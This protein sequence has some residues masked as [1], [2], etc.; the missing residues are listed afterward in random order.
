MNILDKV[1]AYFNPERAA[2]RA[3]FRSSLERGYDAASTD[4]LSGDWMPVF[5]TAEQVAS[6]QRDLIR[7]RARAAELNSDLAESVVLA[8]LRNVVGT[9]IKPQCKIKT[10]AGKLNERLNK[11]IEE[12]WSDWVDKENADIRGISTF[13]ELQEMALRRMVYD[14]EILV[15]MTFE[16]TDIPLSLQLIEG[17]NIGAVSVSENG[18]SIVNGV[19][20]NKYGRPI[21]YHVFQTDPLGIRLFNEARLPSNR[22]FLLHK[23]RRP[24][25]LRGVSML[26]LVL[27][28][29]HDVDEYMDADLIAARVA[30]CFGAFV[31]SNTGGNPMVANKIDSKGKKV[32][33]MAPGIIQH[34]RA[35]ESIS[36]AEPKRNAGTASEYSATQTR[37]IAS[38]MGLS[39]DIVTRNI[40]GNFSAARQNMLE[41]QQSFKQMQRFIIEHFCMPVWQA[42]IEACYLKGIIPANDY[43]ANPK[44]YKKV[45]WLAP[46]WSWIDP[47][48]EVNAN[49]EAIKAG[50][51]T[52]EDVCSASGKDWEEVLEQRKL[53]Q[54]RIKELGVALDM[55]G[56]ITNLADDNA[57]DMKGDDS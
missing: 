53:E 31:T 15:N 27:K 56:D 9:G 22:A 16:G 52:L 39:A 18:N 33:S 20:V 45:A 17:E 14:G 7:G 10:K 29:I 3:Y 36:F 26:A 28:R 19:E 42:F 8:L 55:N 50:L 40:S 21:A 12:A 11:K 1:I 38:G 46:G 25:E 5:G 49:K 47:V 44:L 35:G 2:R 34:L 37:R 32:R 57:T 51:T 24:S 48:K 30:A 13:Y 54:D 41:D 23:P 43:A 6:G 4:R